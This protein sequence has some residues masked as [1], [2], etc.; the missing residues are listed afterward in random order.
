MLALI[1]FATGGFA[2]LLLL[3]S[4][5]LER[6]RDHRLGWSTYLPATLGRVLGIVAIAIQLLEL[7]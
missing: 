2:L 4:L 1:V 5:L 3:A 6:P 7:L